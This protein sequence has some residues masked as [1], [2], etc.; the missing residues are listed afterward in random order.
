MKRNLLACASIL[1]LSMVPIESKANQLYLIEP[2]SFQSSPHIRLARAINHLQ[3]PIIDGSKSGLPQCKPKANSV[4]Y[5]FYSPSRNAM[6]LCTSNGSLDAM[7][8]TFVHETMHMVQDCRAGLGNADLKDKSGHLTKLQ[9]HSLNKEH[10]HN[11]HHL[12]HGESKLF[13]VEA[14]KLDNSPNVVW[15]YVAKYCR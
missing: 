13:E 2:D 4:T 11:I 5:G 7:K 8:R 9:Y 3:V 6:V 14:R 12:Y 10:K 1:A 15:K